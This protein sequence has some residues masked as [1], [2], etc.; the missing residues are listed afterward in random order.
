MSAPWTLGASEC[1]TLLEG[2]LPLLWDQLTGVVPRRASERENAEKL[3]AKIIAENP[4]MRVK[5]ENLILAA[6]M[7]HATEDLH[8]DWFKEQTGLMVHSAQR[9]ITHPDLPLH[10]T[11]DRMTELPD[12]WDVP[13]EMKCVSP[14]TRIEVVIP[15]YAAQVQAQMMMIRAPCAMFSVLWRTPKWAAYTVDAC[16]ATQDELRERLTL[17]AWHVDNR[18]R[19]QPLPPAQCPPPV[20]REFTT[21]V[22]PTSSA[23]SDPAAQETTDA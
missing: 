16:E 18:E 6:R 10:A 17:L 5:P 19:P 2:D 7:G 1:A 4:F 21:R 8:A 22:Q 11:F 13:L 20:W 15:R 14:S 3:A 9:K 12:G 23:A